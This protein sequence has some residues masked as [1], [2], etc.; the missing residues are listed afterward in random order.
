MTMCM[1][2]KTAFEELQINTGNQISRS[3]TE[4]GDLKELG[5]RFA[6][7]FG[8]DAIKNREAVTALHRAGILFASN[9]AIIDDPNPPPNLLFLEILTEFTNK[10]LKQDKKVV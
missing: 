2:L 7:T 3:S 10:L 9:G 4:F 6:L 1:S 8:L 5:K